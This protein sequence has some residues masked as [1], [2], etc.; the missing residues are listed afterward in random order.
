[1]NYVV[2]TSNYCKPW[3]TREDDNYLNDHPSMY[4]LVGTYNTL[5]EA[6]VARKEQTKLEELAE[7]SS[8]DFWDGDESDK[9][10]F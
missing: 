10:I 6:E 9:I 8:A 4:T 3:I 1:M 2:L 7:L 5:A